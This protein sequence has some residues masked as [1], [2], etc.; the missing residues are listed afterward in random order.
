[1]FGGSFVVAGDVGPRAGPSRRASN[2]RLEA[3]IRDFI[4]KAVGSP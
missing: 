4:L 2:V 1:M 3:F